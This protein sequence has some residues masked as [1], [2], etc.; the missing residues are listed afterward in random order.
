M[1]FY[2]IQTL[3]NSGITDIL[4]V[5]GGNHAGDF[6][7]LLRNGQD[8][9]LDH[10]N[11]AYQEGN[12]GI[13]DA[14]RYAKPFVG[15]ENFA[16][17]LGDGIFEDT[18]RNEVS[19]WEEHE[20]SC[21]LFLREVE[22][23][24]EYGIVEIRGKGEDQYLS[25][26]E[27]KPKEPISNTAVTGLYFYTPHVFEIIETLRPSLRGE[28]EISHVNNW[29]IENMSANFNQI[30]G[31]WV[32]CGISVDSLLEASNFLSRKART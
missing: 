27:E 28:L 14:L 3:V 10:L 31:Y 26:I 24:K 9:G 32:D 8:F 7:N 30:T 29:Y 22:N 19:K 15:D 1:I 11:Y 13:A 2:P 21:S 17:I 23:P 20:Q 16:V 18:F 12:G 5:T 4:I 6:L 25:L